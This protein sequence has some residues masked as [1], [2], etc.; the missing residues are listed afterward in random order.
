M[1]P[2]YGLLAVCIP[3]MIF[4]PW[5]LPARMTPLSAIKPSPVAEGKK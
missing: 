5:A 1:N 4:V 2:Y 3:M